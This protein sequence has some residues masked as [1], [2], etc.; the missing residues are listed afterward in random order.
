ME[1]F[2]T[3]A[4]FKHR[5]P[6]ATEPEDRTAL[7]IVTTASADGGIREVRWAVID[8]DYAR[9]LAHANA[10]DP[11]T[12]PFMPESAQLTGW[13]LGYPDPRHLGSLDP[14]A[15]ASTAPPAGAGE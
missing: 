5:I 11:D 2:C 9:M 15:R 12:R 8:G 7:A 6:P 14:F 13:M 3:V 4:I 10:D 1:L